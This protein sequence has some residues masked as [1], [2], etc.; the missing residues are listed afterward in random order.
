MLVSCPMKQKGGE[1]VTFLFII[2]VLLLLAQTTRGT[3]V[4]SLTKE[5]IRQQE[6]PHI[7]S[8]QTRSSRVPVFRMKAMLPV[9]TVRESFRCH[10]S[11]SLCNSSLPLTR[12]HV[13]L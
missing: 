3:G 4:W 8:I 7:Q 12:D 11:V 10:G 6:K 1:E 9:L 2:F 13:V 5:K